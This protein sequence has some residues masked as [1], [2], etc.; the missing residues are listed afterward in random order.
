[1]QNERTRPERAGKCFHYKNAV[2]AAERGRY[3]KSRDYRCDGL[4]RR[5]AVGILT[6]HKNAE[7]KWYGSRSYIDER[8][9]DVYR[10]M[11]RIVD[12]VCRDDNLK[13]LAKQVDVIFTAT[14]QG[15]L[16]SVL[17]EEILAQTKV[18]DFERGFSYQG[19]GYI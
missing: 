4:C 10:N 6:G 1:M 2:C 16:A 12:D 13:E 14:P 3:D 18:I 9:A 5:R 11:F 7:I 15:F 8:Y 19:C 17:D